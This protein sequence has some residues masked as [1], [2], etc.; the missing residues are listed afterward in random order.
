[1]LVWVEF[2]LSVNPFRA[3]QSSKAPEKFR[4]VHSL[5]PYATLQELGI[6]IPQISYFY[7]FIVC[8]S[9][10]V[11]QEYPRS[12]GSC[13][14]FVRMIYDKKRCILNFWTSWYQVSLDS[15]TPKLY[16]RYHKVRWQG[17]KQTMSKITGA[18][19]KF[20]FWYH[21]SS[22]FHWLE[23]FIWYILQHCS[24]ISVFRGG[25]HLPANFP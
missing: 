12:W 21:N 11:S 5:S 13:D 4:A 17:I 20:H 22:Y 2:W 10:R 7:M 16:S 3:K 19:W 1:M 9:P 8:L 25:I 15:M 18:I 14:H 6:S 24:A 23:E